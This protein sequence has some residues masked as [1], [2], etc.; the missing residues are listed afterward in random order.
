MGR[1]GKRLKQSVAATLVCCALDLSPVFAAPA[2]GPAAWQGESPAGGILLVNKS[3]KLPDAY[4][5][6][7]DL[8]TA[9]NCFGKEFQLERETCEHFLSLRDDLM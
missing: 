7:V 4:E 3:H 2:D 1:Y 9:R 8:V 5:A 6:K